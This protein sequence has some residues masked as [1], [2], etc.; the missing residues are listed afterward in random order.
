MTFF[1]GLKNDDKKRYFLDSYW[2]NK[3][4]G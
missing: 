4:G 3:L 1:Q 2:L